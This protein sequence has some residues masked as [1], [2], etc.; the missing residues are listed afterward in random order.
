MDDIAGQAS[1]GLDG[2]TFIASDVG[3]FL[4]LSEDNTIAVDR[5]KSG[6]EKLNFEADDLL[7]ATRGENGIFC[8]SKLG[9]K[10]KSSLSSAMLRVELVDVTFSEGDTE[11]L[12]DL[13]D[14]SCCVG[15]LCRFAFV[16]ATYPDALNEG[17]LED[18]L[19][20]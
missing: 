9:L 8:V 6:E 19:G 7:P 10:E 1:D 20:A 13:F 4:S 16:L 15:V 5:F 17:D 2:L 12:S 11:C 14:G 18:E 3:D